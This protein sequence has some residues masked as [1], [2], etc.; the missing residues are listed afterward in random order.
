MI[1]NLI[2]FLHF[3]VVSFVTFGLLIIP[4]GFLFKWSWTKNRNFRLIHIFLMGFIT[5]ETLMGLTCP[6]TYIENA[7]R[8]TD[9]TT[10]FISF[11]LM[12]I[13][14][15]DMPSHFFIG[16]YL[17]CVTWLLVFWRLHPPKKHRR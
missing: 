7:L 1:A 4:L 3:G 11:W 6:L 16:L 9:Q 2:L 10:T 14:Y 12:K 15:W 17:I 5:I 13:I 8:G